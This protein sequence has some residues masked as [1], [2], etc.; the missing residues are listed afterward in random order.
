MPRPIGSSCFL[1]NTKT[2]SSSWWFLYAKNTAVCYSYLYMNNFLKSLFVATTLFLSIFSFTSAEVKSDNLVNIFVFERD[3]CNFCQ[4]EK[5][6]LNSLLSERKDFNLIYLDVNEVEAKQKFNQL[7]EFY[8]IPK[9]TPI[10]LVGNSVFQGFGSDETT[11]KIIVSALD[12][13]QKGDTIF[14]FDDYLTTNVTV[15]SQQDSTCDG[16]ESLSCFVATTPE[17]EI[18]IP[19]IGVINYKDFSL[20]SMAAILGFVDGF[21]PCAMWVLLAFLLVLWQIGNKKKMFQVAGLFIFAEALMYWLILNFWFKTWDFVG[22]DNIV[23][24]AVGLLAVAGGIYFL[25]RYFKNRN[26]LVCDV[27]SAEYHSKTEKKIKDL[28]K[29]PLTIVTALGIIG[30]AFSINIIEFA[31]SVGI[32][33]TFTKVLEINNLSASLDQFYI[34][35]YTLFYMVDDFVVFGLALYGFDRFYTV[36]QKYSNLSSLIGGILMII[37]GAI[38]IFAPGLLVF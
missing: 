1:P 36:G 30:V 15:D 5:V 38:L 27:T 13:F 21:N 24:P 16:E 19:F 9:A 7:T 31:C 3:N 25:R 4:L 28:I 35:I 12:N 17:P 26:Q 2:A 10:T 14:A 20:F 23:T 6:F 18:K 11:G 29:S 33:Q 34:L 32:P 37:L 8:D 22:W